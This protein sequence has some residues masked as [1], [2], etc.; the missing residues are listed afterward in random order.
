M[1]E[2]STDESSTRPVQPETLRVV[3]NNIPVELRAVDQWVNW[4][5]ELGKDRRW[6]KVPHRALDGKL[7]SSTDPETWAS[8]FRVIDAYEA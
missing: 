3:Q 6:T 8:I 1:L 2:S 4:R 7:A 5:Y